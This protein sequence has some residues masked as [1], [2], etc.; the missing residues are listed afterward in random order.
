[1]RK[2]QIRPVMVTYLIAAI[3]LHKCFEETPG[4]VT[5]VAHFLSRR[6][7]HSRK[8]TDRMLAGCLWDTRQ[9]HRSLLTPIPASV[10]AL[11]L[12]WA[13]TDRRFPCREEGWITAVSP[14]S[15]DGLWAN[16]F[17]LK[18]DSWPSKAKQSIFWNTS[19]DPVQIIVKVHIIHESIGKL[20]LKWRVCKD[21]H[22]KLN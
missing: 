15:T 18:G 11:S 20:D 10:A 5:D 7:H 3:L 6:P 19:R 17:I 1:M 4:P 21:L 2:T 12:Y 9:W 8:W 13:A 14:Y 16:L 22:F